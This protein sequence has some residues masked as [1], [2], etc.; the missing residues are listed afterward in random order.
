MNFGSLNEF[1]EFYK[2]I[3]NFRKGKN[4]CVRPNLAQG[5]QPHGLAAHFARLAER[6]R[7]LGSWPNHVRGPVDLACSRHDARP[8]ARGAVTAHGPAWLRGSW[9]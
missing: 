9:W 8:G 3:N 6:L 5:L 7:G 1:L 4:D 2:R